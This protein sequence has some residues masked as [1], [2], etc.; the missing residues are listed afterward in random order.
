MTE[1]KQN[2]DFLIQGGTL[3]A[4]A[5]FGRTV[6]LIYRIPLTAIL[7][8]LGNNYYCCAFDVYNIMLLVSS[9]S[10]PLAVSRLV[11]DY[12]A[13]GERANAYRV[14]QCAF[15]FALLAGGAACAAVFVGAGYLTDTVFRTPQSIYALRVLAPVL[16]LTA[17]LGVFRGYFQGMERMR[18]SAV[19]QA[20][21][22]LVN[23][24]VSVAAAYAFSLYGIQAQGDKTNDGQAAYG[25]AGAAFGTLSGAAAALFFLLLFSLKPLREMRREGK[26][27]TAAQTPYRALYKAMLRTV[28]PILAASAFY[29]LN[30]VMEQGIFK[31]MA[32]GRIAQEQIARLWGIFSGKFKT[33]VNFP[34]AVAAAIG[35]ACIPG[36]TASLTAGD[37]ARASEKTGLAVRFCMV[38]TLPA[39]FALTFLADPVMRLLFGDSGGTAA[40]LLFWGAPVIALYSLGA[41]TSGILQGVGRLR[42]PVANG[43]AALCAEL[44]VLYLLL[45]FTSLGIYA[46]LPAMYT[47]GVSAA[48]L[49]LAAL[50]KTGYWK[51]QPGKDF[52]LPAASALVMAAVSRFVGLVFGYALPLSASLPASVAAGVAS[53]VFLLR[54]RRTE[55]GSMRGHL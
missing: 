52:L 10:L 32:A 53:Y 42:A 30:V 5:V 39:A 50:Y 46:L 14:L 2:R 19:S 7:G 40:G 54:R 35:A 26:R 11:S 16:A 48:A 34:V 21:E 43:A 20:L 17:L 28:L 27:E 36:I 4:A 3:A 44:A 31:H 15:V 18:P 29:N 38:L 12:R 55:D 6:G 8:D 23:A 45:R 13:K 33:L 49:N 37:F 47:F 51:P 24:F 9:Y 41:V 22:Q 25:A 1:N